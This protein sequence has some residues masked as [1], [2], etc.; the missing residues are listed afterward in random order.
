MEVIKSIDGFEQLN[1][2]P[3][4]KRKVAHLDNL[5]V[6]VIEFFEHLI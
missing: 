1:T 4:I 5:M 2:T 6:T 3:P